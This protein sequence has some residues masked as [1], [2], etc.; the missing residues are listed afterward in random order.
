MGVVLGKSKCMLVCRVCNYSAVF[1]LWASRRKALVLWSRLLAFHTLHVRM[2]VV[3]LCGGR[4]LRLGESLSFGE[5][6]QFWAIICKL[7]KILAFKSHDVSL[8]VCSI[9]GQIPGNVTIDMF[10]LSVKSS[11]LCTISESLNCL[12]I[13]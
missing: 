4:S 8:C 6:G 2:L 1:E 13:K 7:C 10:F 9:L 5:V 3:S 12:K 11:W